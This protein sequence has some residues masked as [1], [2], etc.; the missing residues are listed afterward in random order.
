MVV[1]VLCLIMNIP[2]MGHCWLAHP[3]TLDRTRWRHFCLAGRVWLGQ[4][5]S[6][7]KISAV[8]RHMHGI[9][10]WVKTYGLTIFRGNKWNNH[11]SLANI[12]QLFLGTIRVPGFWPTTISATILASNS[13][14]ASGNARLKS[15]L[16]ANQS[17]QESLQKLWDVGVC[18]CVWK[19]NI[20]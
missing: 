16:A 1:H 9:W 4:N 2:D 13:A 19:W 6:L 15:A 18:V 5:E 3:K 7:L 12:K 8:C 17:F 20:Y 14:A 11:S 10:G